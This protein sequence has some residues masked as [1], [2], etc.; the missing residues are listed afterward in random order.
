MSPES[1]VTVPVPPNCTLPPAS[2]V[3][4]ARVVTAPSGPLKFVTP[5][6]F[7][8]R[9]NPPL[10]APLK[11]MSPCA[12]GVGSSCPRLSKKTSTPKAIGLL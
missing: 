5:V 3:T 2:V 6:V 8:F 7:T 12:T 4:L 10:I 1:V 9:L 11:V